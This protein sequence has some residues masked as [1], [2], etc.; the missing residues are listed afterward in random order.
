MGELTRIVDQLSRAYQGDAWHGPSL[1]RILSDVDPAAAAAR[2]IAGAHTIAELVLHIAAWEEIVRRRLEGEAIGSVPDQVDWPTAPEPLG[3]PAWE[4]ARRR[5]DD[6]HR[7]L[8][9]AVAR[10]DDSRLGDPVAEKD[11]TV[12]IMLH[13]IV[14]HD[15]YHAGQIALLKK[16]RAGR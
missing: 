11:Y 10:I 16:A 14:Q 4:A 13:G 3:A 7:R 12:Y 8:L 9:A 6:G 2:S 1:T 5:L 15:L